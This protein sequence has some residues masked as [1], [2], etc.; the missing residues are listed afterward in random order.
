MTFD[1]LDAAWWPY[2]FIVLAAALPTYSWRALGVVLGG[3]LDERSE[4]LVFARAVA[5]AL[6]AGV[7]A[8]LVLYP[9]GA[10][11]D[12][13]LALRLAACICGMAV[14][15]FTGRRTIVAVLVTEA[16]LLTGQALS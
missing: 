3:R 1:A 10:A 4:I 11:A 14:W 15:A 2:A 12:F 16:I 7:V 6:V 13:P 5:T 8:K 9:S